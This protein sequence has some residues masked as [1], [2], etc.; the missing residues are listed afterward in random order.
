M[1][2]VSLKLSATPRQYDPLDQSK[3]RSA[4]EQ[5]DKDNLKRGAA[6]DY[7]LLSKP[8]GTVGKLTVD[9]AGVL[10]WTAL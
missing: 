10:S 8:D 7:L 6:V 3:M 1:A 4:I 5:A 9:N 2:T